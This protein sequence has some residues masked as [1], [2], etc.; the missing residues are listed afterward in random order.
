MTYGA[1]LYALPHRIPVKPG[2]DADM[3]QAR[4]ADLARSGGLLRFTY[5]RA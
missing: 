5:Q 2:F 4:A 3:L 1:I